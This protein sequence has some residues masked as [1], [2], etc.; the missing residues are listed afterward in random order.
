[1]KRTRNIIALALGVFALIIT[2][3]CTSSSTTN[4][5]PESASAISPAS[6]DLLTTQTAQFT[7]SISKDPRFLIWSVNGIEHGN[8]TVGTIDATGN[9]TAPAMQP[10]APVTITVRSALNRAHSG[11]AIATV[12]APGEVA[13]TANPQVALYT[14]APSVA[15]MVSI[16]FG[17]DTTY[18][19]TTWTQQAA[20]N[21]TPFAMYVAGMK[22][23]TLYHMRA[24]LQMPDGTQLFDLDH[25]F[26]TGTLPANAI[27][28]LTVTIPNGLVPQPGVELVDLLGSG[29]V[30]PISVT[31]LSG[32]LLWGYQP[33]G[34]ASDSVQPVKLLP[35]GHFILVYAPGSSIFINPPNLPPGTLDVAREID[36]AGNTI[37]EISIDT[38][39]TRLAAAGFNYV[40]ATMHHDIT[41]LPNGHWIL[42]VNSTQ[43]FTNLTGLPGTTTVLGD[44]L[45]DL[46][47]NLNPVWMWN[48]FDHLDVNRHPMA[49]PDWTHSNAV[50]YSATDGNLLLSMRHQN[51]I[52]KI[53]YANGQGAG[54]IIWH[55]GYQG[56]FTLAGGS[57]P[58][59][60]FY[61]QHGPSYT[62]QATAGVFGMT[63]FDNGDDRVFPAGQS[64]TTLGLPTCPYS[65]TQV[66][67]ID[68]TAKTATFAFHDILSTYSFF[69][70]NADVLANGNVHYDLAGLLGPTP[71][72][73]IYEVTPT[74]PAQTVWQMS[75]PK[76]Y[77]Y[78][79]YRLPSLYPGVQW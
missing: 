23:S 18:G 36:L 10:S 37:R 54:D 3:G 15:A 29:T 1:M 57:T 26:T 45:I 14:I 19:L 21:A 35:N 33:G 71:S 60:W 79:A 76:H 32:N 40:A 78:R 68:E 8:A 56:D 31:D 9:Y 47:T 17:T 63:V 42:I 67:M 55:L 51:W 39:N 50:L 49:F 2:A 34:T 46:D 74:S 41:V 58:M 38:L 53:D 5:N 59:D 24:V 12:V 20:G 13:A 30:P 61:A 70:G 6:V 16:Q 22:A 11:S 4:S 7:T 75:S 72:S 77:A 52:I 25:I 44:A 28:T 62:T 48:T 66:L 27:P 65:T 69:G 73:A 43:Q 64:C